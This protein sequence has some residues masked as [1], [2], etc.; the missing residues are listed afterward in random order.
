MDIGNEGQQR[1]ASFCPPV[2]MPNS[3]ACLIELVVSPPALARPTTL[4][5]DD[6]ACN[7]NDEKSGVFSAHVGCSRATLPP[8][9]STTAV[10][11]AL[12]RAWPKA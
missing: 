9:A 6:C 2:V 11:S 1:A 3:C 7:K 5:F 8:L 12:Q 10:V 4:A